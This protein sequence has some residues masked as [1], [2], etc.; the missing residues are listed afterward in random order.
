MA[1]EGTGGRKLAQLVPDHI[2]AD[3]DRHMT[4]PIMHGN[5]MADHLWEDSRGPRPSLDHTL[6][7]ARAVHLFNPSQ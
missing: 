1:A 2:L 3:I 7:Y 4:P 5:G 6:G